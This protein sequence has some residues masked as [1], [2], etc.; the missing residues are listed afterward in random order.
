[1]ARC[2]VARIAPLPHRLDQLFEQ[3]STKNAEASLDMS[4]FIGQYVHGN[5]PSHHIAYLYAY[6]GKQWKTA[7][8]VRQILD[9]MYTDQP[10]RAL[11]QRGLRADVSLVRP[12]GLGLLPGRSGRRR[13][14][15]RESGC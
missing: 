11:R 13:L 14:R 15:D 7:D 4:G 6:A 12:L 5:E 1:M 2:W 9:E 3:D 10:R 8:R